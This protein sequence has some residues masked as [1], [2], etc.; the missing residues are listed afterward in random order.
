MFLFWNIR[1]DDTNDDWL[2]ITKNGIHLPKGEIM[3]PAGDQQSQSVC[4][5]NPP[6]KKVT[7]SYII[8]NLIK[9]SK[10]EKTRWVI[11]GTIW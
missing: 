9:F 1:G 2:N 10:K 11:W 6:Q 4:F 7:G 3:K 5:L 8:H